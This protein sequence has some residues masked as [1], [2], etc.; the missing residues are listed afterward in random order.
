MATTNDLLQH[1]ADIYEPELLLPWQPA[2]GHYVIMVL[3]L[4]LLALLAWRGYQYWQA[5][6]PKRLAWQTLQQIRWQEPAA[7]EHINHLLKRLLRTY[8]PTH[9]MLS[10]PITAWQAFL[11]QQ[12][13]TTLPLPNLQH[14]LYKAPST[15]ETEAHQQFWL[16]AA[17]I[18]KHFS[19]KRFAPT[20]TAMLGTHHA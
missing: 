12:L 3:A 4:L 15:A 7:A 16:A 19:K 1:L 10:A 18:I 5:Q 14:L 20:A 11:Q 8:H 9:P 6:A 17:Y 13:P 2:L